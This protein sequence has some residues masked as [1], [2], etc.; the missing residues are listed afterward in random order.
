MCFERVFQVIRQGNV[1]I[2]RCLGSRG[3]VYSVSLLGSQ[4]DVLIILLCIAY[5]LWLAGL[6][7]S[8]RLVSPLP[9]RKRRSLRGVAGSTQVDA[10]RWS[11]RKAAPLAQSSHT[12]RLHSRLSTRPPGSGEVRTSSSEEEAAMTTAAIAVIKVVKV[13]RIGIIVILAAVEDGGAI[14]HIVVTHHHQLRRA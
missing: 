6:G 7:F 12:C 2:S 8:T 13:A 1:Y 9:V 14:E 3:G 5:H 11:A 10:K 4:P